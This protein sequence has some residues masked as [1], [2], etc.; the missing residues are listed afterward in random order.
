MD[1]LKWN[2]TL[3]TYSDYVGVS[4]EA[5][6]NLRP[7]DVKYLSYNFFSD[8]ASDKLCSS[9]RPGLLTVNDIRSL[10]YLPDGKIMY[11]CKFSED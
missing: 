4:K 6:Q 7:Y 9:I 8:Y 11:N 1:I 10:K 2:V 5:R 3:K